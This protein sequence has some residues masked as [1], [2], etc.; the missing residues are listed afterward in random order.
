MARGSSNVR[1][2]PPQ[3]L[4]RPPGALAPTA[5]A[6]AQATATVTAPVT[7]ISALVDTFPG[8]TL[9]TTKWAVNSGS[10]SVNNGL[11]LPVVPSYSAINSLHVYDLTGSAAYVQATNPP[12]GTNQSNEVALQLVASLSNQNLAQVYMIL[13][14]QGGVQSGYYV[15]GTQFTFAGV[16]TAVSPVWMRI[17]ESAGT[18][19]YEYAL[20]PGGTTWVQ[21]ATLTPTFA[22]TALYVVLSAGHW[23]AETD[24][25]AYYNNFNSPTRIVLPSADVAATGW[26]A[27]PLWS[28]VA[29]QSDS[30]VI[31]ATLA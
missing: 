12:V 25:T 18:V 7:P 8:T 23:A 13:G 21:A 14:D 30:T 15:G 4:L 19:Y 29:D 6:T 28:K 27:T 22:V 1:R 2:A 20:D 31:T 9:D 17:R 26:A 16:F 10:P 11:I 3:P 24:T 5:Q